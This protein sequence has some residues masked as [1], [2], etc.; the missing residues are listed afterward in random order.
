MKLKALAAAVALMST[1]TVANAAWN[2]GK[3]A[4]SG[5]ASGNGE[6]VLLVWDQVLEVSVVQDLGDSYLNFYDNSQNMGFEFDATLDA[7]FAST[8]AQSNAADIQWSVF[9]N[10]AG[11]TLSSNPERYKNG[12][13]VTVNDAEAN[14]TVDRSI[15]SNFK[16]VQDKVEGGMSSALNTEMGG[17]VADNT[18]FYGDLANGLYAGAPEVYGANILDTFP[19]NVAAASTESMYFWAFESTFAGGEDTKFVGKWT[20]DLA[21]NG[22][23]Y[24]PVPVPAAVWLLASG[25]LG[26]GA[27][28]RRR[29]A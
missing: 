19:V 27:I 23:S 1:A 7:L 18:A 14:P 15:A 17:T 12:F 3:N 8:F 28:S 16:Q 26:L 25:L 10:S 5:A 4:V 29:K 9:A 6:L 22:L 20:L 11:S 2:D 21:G 13:M 24:T